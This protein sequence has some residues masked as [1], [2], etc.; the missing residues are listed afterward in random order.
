MRVLHIIPNLQVGGAETML[1]RLMGE[2]H[3]MDDSGIESHVVAL[4][5]GGPLRDSIEA[6]GVPVT[7]LSDEAGPALAVLIRRVRLFRPDVIQTW[8]Y[9]A[10]LMGAIASRLTG[11]GAVVWNL[12]C[13]FGWAERGFARRAVFSGLRMLSTV[14]AAVVS[15][16][17]RAIDEHRAAG[18]NARRW[19]L[20]PNGFDTDV[21]RPSYEVRIRLRSDLGLLEDTPLVGMVARFDPLKDHETFLRAAKQLVEEGNNA[22]FVLVGARLEENLRGV[23]EELGLRDRV[24]VLGYRS[25]IPDI[26]PGFDVSALSSLSEGFPNVVGE[27]MACGLPCVSTRVGDIAKLLDAEWIIEPGDYHALARSWQKLLALPVV[28]RQ[29]IGASNRRRIE[30]DYSAKLVADRYRKLYESIYYIAPR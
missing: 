14:P 27:A 30:S 1:T 11:L 25:D 9:R 29:S 7:V 2:W 12:R 24:H 16:T 22:H 8:M 20:I 15:N 13:S 10:D 17:G 6:F 3:R 26:V 19:E 4:D 23:I 18:Y 21:Y 28:D 5:G